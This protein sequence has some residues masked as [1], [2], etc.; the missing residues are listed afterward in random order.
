M[1]ESLML[2]HALPTTA[3]V[4]ADSL[5]SAALTVAPFVQSAA[6]GALACLVFHTTEYLLNKTSLK[7]TNSIFPL[8]LAVTAAIVFT[9]VYAAAFIGII[10][11]PTSLTLG[12]L[13]LTA[14]AAHY[15]T[16]WLIQRATQSKALPEVFDELVKEL[17]ASPIKTLYVYKGLPVY[18]GETS[19]FEQMVKSCGLTCVIEW[20][21]DDFD[22]STWDPASSLLFIPGAESKE[23]HEH[24]G[25][26]I[27]AI[28]DYVQ[29]G[30]HCIGWCGGGYW[31]AKEVQFQLSPSN[32]IQR[33][34][35]LALWKGVAKGPLLPYTPSPERKIKFLQKAVKVKWHGSDTLR[36]YVPEGI[37]LNVFLSGGGSLIPAADEYPYKIMQTYQETAPELALAGAKT[38]I[39]KGNAIINFSYLTYGV[40]Y[41]KERLEQFKQHFP[42]QPW[43]QTLQDLEACETERKV[44]FVD[45]LLEASSSSSSITL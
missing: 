14:A 36:K 40:D 18:Y 26:K 41:F 5:L 44:C 6:M 37:N 45:L 15:A 3:A 34:R 8:S 12:A 11:M 21:D 24:L 25:S 32:K 20:V 39:G 4:T 1:I 9:A 16:K 2:T 43:D 42:E 28:R 38:Y 7:D 13:V 33:T 30:G 19:A 17:N 35:D 31:F 27:S 29:R 23:L 10:T 22:M